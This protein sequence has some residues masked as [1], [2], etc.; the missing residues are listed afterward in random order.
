MW[1]PCPCWVVASCFQMCSICPLSHSG[2]GWTLL[3]SAQSAQQHSVHGLEMKHGR[4]RGTSNTF[5][6]PGICA[7][8]V[9][10]IP[11]PGLSSACVQGRC[12][13]VVTSLASG[14]KLWK[15]GHCQG[16][17]CQVYPGLISPKCS[18]RV[19]LEEAFVCLS[20]AL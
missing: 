19:G 6:V 18:P 5:P 8:S 14:L 15:Q 10:V 20:P 2:C 3:P 7:P 17:S 13:F 4:G 11:C 1:P 12:H 9:R 16:L